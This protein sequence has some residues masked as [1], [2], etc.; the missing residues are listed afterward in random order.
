MSARRS[1]QIVKAR[2]AL[3]V[4]E[5]FA[6]AGQRG[7][8]GEMDSTAKTPTWGEAMNA[9]GMVDEL[10]RAMLAES[11]RRSNAARHRKS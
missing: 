6:L 1:L 7:L 4:L 10:L 8:S 11:D 5:D 3:G 2:E 9:I